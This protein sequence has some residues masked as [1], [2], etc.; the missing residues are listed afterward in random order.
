MGN[1]TYEFCSE[2]WV[3]VADAFLK[4]AAK[5]ADLSGI[6]YTFNEVFTDAPAHLGTD[7]QGRV[8]WYLRVADG[9]VEAK[10]GILDDADV[11]IEADYQGILPLARAVF[12]DNP[13]GAVQAGK[14]IEEM[15]AAGK[16]KHTANVAEPPE[17]PW[18]GQL[19]DV[20]ARHTA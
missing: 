15:T 11:V 5:D 4:E 19:H 3:G 17:M 7:A 8:G 1:E 18:T 10:Q 20:L 12:A 6:S 14:T 2:Q 13:E 16:F 9:Q